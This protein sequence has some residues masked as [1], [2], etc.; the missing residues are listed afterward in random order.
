[1]PLD[2]LTIAG[3]IASVSKNQ[4]KNLQHSRFGGHDDVFA[5][6]LMTL[7]IKL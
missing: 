7:F 4:F 6:S 5:K 2:V 1:M 3:R